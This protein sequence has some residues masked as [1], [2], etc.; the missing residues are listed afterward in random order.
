MNDITEAIKLPDKA[1]EV[2]YS[3]AT[4][5]KRNFLLRLFKL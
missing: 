4:Y 2:L 3:R 5:A 1:V